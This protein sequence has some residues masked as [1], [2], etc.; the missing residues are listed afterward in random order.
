MTGGSMDYLNIEFQG[1]E[2]MTKELI[3]RLG[4]YYNGLNIQKFIHI[5]NHK[6]TC[7]KFYW[8]EAIINILDEEPDR[9]VL[10]FDEII[11]EMLANAWYSVRE[12]H[13]HMGNV[14]NKKQNVLEKAVNNAAQMTGLPSD[15]TK[16]EIKYSF[17]KESGNKQF[18]KD[19]NTLMQEV[20]FHVLSPFYNKEKYGRA[21]R[22]LNTKDS[23]KYFNDINKTFLL[24]YSFG[25]DL[26][27]PTIIVDS[28]WK[29]M[30]IDNYVLLKGWI[31]FQKIKYL[32][33]RN[34]E[35]PGIIY[36]LDPSKNN[37]RKLTKVRDMW[38]HVMDI[39]PVRDIYNHAFLCKNSY[40]VDHFIPWSFLTC[41][42]LWDLVPID[43][44][45]NSQK[46]NGLPSWDLYFNSFSQTQYELYQL[47]FTNDI[48]RECF[49]SCRKDNLKTY[50]GGE[51]LFCPGKTE[52]EFKGTLEAHLKQHYDAARRQGYNVWEYKIVES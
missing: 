19:K 41:D 3:S 1:Q 27:R 26:N 46:S 12:Y 48:I 38:D 24:P 25:E 10:S 47:V 2:F 5:F 17:R 13:L 22:K 20:P 43:S 30:F 42:E 50:W 8:M 45:V 16:K 33:D 44:S 40:D 7:Y 32:Q 4:L 51:E 49:A 18:I 15:A 31:Q 52:T 23:I 21:L 34:P 39:R 36:K 6:D 9:T 29:Q 28:N 11:E 37:I 14:K 35:V